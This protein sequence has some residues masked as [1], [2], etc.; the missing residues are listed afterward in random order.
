[1]S[2]QKRATLTEKEAQALGVNYQRLADMAREQLIQHKLYLCGI[3]KTHPTMD[4]AFKTQLIEE[5]A[6][7]EL[8]WV[9]AEPS[10][11][12]ASKADEPAAPTISAVYTYPD[13]LHAWLSSP[14]CPPGVNIALEGGITLD[15]KP[16]M[17]RS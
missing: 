6:Q 7:L 2:N 11:K 8:S 12:D 3:I 13:A 16:A 1:M 5:V 15:E 17:V 9:T 14:A 10:I 4:D